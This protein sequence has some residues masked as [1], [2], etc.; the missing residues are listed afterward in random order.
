VSRKLGARI[1][2]GNT[3]DVHVWSKTTVI[4]VLH[5]G[6]PASWA[7]V[8]AATTRSV[9]E[10]GLPAPA[11]IDILMLGD[12]PAIVLDHVEGETMLDRML[13]HPDEVPGMIRLLVD[14]QADLNATIAPPGLPPLRDRLRANI[15]SAKWL[16]GSQRATAHR[17]LD[18]LP[19]G[20]AV[21]HFDFHPTNVMIG[22]KGPVVIDWFDAAVGDPAADRVR[23]SLLLCYGSATEHDANAPQTAGLYRA[24]LALLL[25]MTTVDEESL[26]AW[27]PAV[28]AG[29]LAEPVS[30]GLLRETRQAF[31]DSVAGSSRLGR[32]IRES[33]FSA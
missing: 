26:L 10:A 29:R 27:E 6:I 32:A 9:H 21:C 25:R 33:R 14:L 20:N 2:R 4:K 30:K 5:R 3:S 8:E 31:S 13:A 7:E 11:V 16:A 15:A 18:G 17:I 23:T 12:R 19:E 22:P 24:Y 1:A 28:T